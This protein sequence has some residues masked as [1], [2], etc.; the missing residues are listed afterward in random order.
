[1]FNSVVRQYSDIFPQNEN[2]QQYL[3]ITKGQS[4]LVKAA[5][6]ALHA[7]H[8]LDSTTIAKI[9]SRSQS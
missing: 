2:Q 9:C 7:L 3:K 6:N 4:N 8:A 1:M 5:S